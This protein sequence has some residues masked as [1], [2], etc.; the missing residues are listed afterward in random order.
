MRFE[1]EQE[2]QEETVPRMTTAQR[3]AMVITVKKPTTFE[4]VD[5]GI[6]I[7][8]IA[9]NGEHRQALMAIYPD[10]T[11][12]RA[13]LSPEKSKEQGIQRD[14]AGEFMECCVAANRYSK[15]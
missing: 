13:H 14:K 1:I 9:T 5:D 11:F 2:K 15:S 3:D 6:R 10:G 12:V 8:L 4:L 7:K